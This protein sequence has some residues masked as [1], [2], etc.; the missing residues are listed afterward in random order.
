M[1]NDIS[2]Y[3]AYYA[4]T[5]R[6]GVIVSKLD[7]S[8]LPMIRYT[9]AYDRLPEPFLE[10]QDEAF[11]VYKND[12]T[13]KK[14]VV[15]NFFHMINLRMIFGTDE[16]RELLAQAKQE[17]FPRYGKV[18][19]VIVAQ[20]SK[21]SL[22]VEKEYVQYSSQNIEYV[23]PV[24]IVAQ[25]CKNSLFVEKE[26]IQ[27]SSQNIE[28]IS[29]SVV[30]VQENVVD[31]NLSDSAEFADVCVDNI[32]E[33]GDFESKKIDFDIG[34]VSQS[35]SSSFKCCSTD[36]SGSSD[37]CCSYKKTLDWLDGNDLSNY[38]EKESYKLISFSGFNIIPMYDVP[39]DSSGDSGFSL[40]FLFKKF[41]KKLGE[42]F[43][44][45]VQ[46]GRLLGGGKHG[47]KKLSMPSFV[48]GR[49][50]LGGKNAT[51]LNK[52]NGRVRDKKFD[53]FDDADSDDPAY[54]DDNIHQFMRDD[55]DEYPD[56]GE[57]SSG[58]DS[59]S[60]IQTD[61]VVKNRVEKSWF[62]TGSFDA[63]FGDPDDDVLN[64]SYASDPYS[65]CDVRSE[66]GNDIRG[67]YINGTQNCVVEIQV[68]ID[69]VSKVDFPFKL[70]IWCSPDREPVGSLHNSDIEDIKDSC[71]FRE[72][73]IEP[74]GV[75]NVENFV[76]NRQIFVDQGADPKLGIVKRNDTLPFFIH[77][78][79]FGSYY[80][81]EN[82][83]NIQSVVTLTLD[84][85]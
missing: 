29:P 32:V 85:G 54:L 46:K 34:S 56:I 35:L 25:E 11:G 17:V 19:A 26:H 21:N 52:G 82:V 43:G 76:S 68:D 83:A 48:L 53:Y 47:V 18:E 77:V 7:G 9:Q 22:F 39:H 8:E 10:L 40:S 36:S 73:D 58:D 41:K 74:M 3:I 81:P 59:N 33:K 28:Y 13:Y 63:N 69:L 75:I 66:E 64:W 61:Y 62:W 4:L 5:Q 6:V 84:K 70:L 67:F 37:L 30:I 2:E 27:Y 44:G 42:I 1:F 71:D 60:Y 65:V 57:D 55:L 20:E 80:W 23:A 12:A 78:A 38:T 24:I 16:D 51:R 79:L 15:V 50:L 14:R 45:S 72:Y 31:E 49:N